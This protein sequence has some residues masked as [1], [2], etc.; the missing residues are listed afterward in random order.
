S[1]LP[2]GGRYFARGRE[3]RRGRSQGAARHFA[4]YERLWF[5]SEI[6]RKLLSGTFGQGEIPRPRA[7]TWTAGRV[8]QAPLCLSL[9]ACRR[10]D[11][12]DGGRKNPALSRHSVSAREPENFTRDEASRRHREDL[13]AHREM[14]RD[15]P[16][17]DSA[18]DLHRWLSWRDRRRF[19][20]A[21]RLASRRKDRSRGR[22][23]I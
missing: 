18:L 6:C 11:R 3:A 10:G 21:S 15:L 22:L 7:G 1:L 12:T 9:S 4:R 8:D 2:R 19:R 16:R 17:S 20:D 14:A 23:Q 5:G 13:G